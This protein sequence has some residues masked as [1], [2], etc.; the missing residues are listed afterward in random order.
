MRLSICLLLVLLPFAG[1]HA[2]NER[3]GEY[4][5]IRDAPNRETDTARQLN[6]EAV[7]L[8]DQGRYDEAE[9]RLKEALAADITFGPAHNNLGRVYFHQQKLYL[10]AWEFEYAIKLMPHHVEPRNNLG[11]VFEA[12]GKLDDA[13]THYD[14]A[15]A[16][17]PDNPFVTGNLTRARIRRGDRGDEVRRLLR[18]IVMK[19]VRSEWVEWARHKLGTEYSDE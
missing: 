14:R 17:E 9:Q 8:I 13:V 2:P 1:C 10:A 5:T 18:E 15:L 4:K 7:D 19:D 16:L 11:L 12:V 3:S 6:A